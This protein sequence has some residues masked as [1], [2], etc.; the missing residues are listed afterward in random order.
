MDI[1]RVE[2]NTDA[3]CTR[4]NCH[5]KSVWSVSSLLALLQDGGSSKVGASWSH[6]KR[7]APQSTWNT[8]ATCHRGS[9][10]TL[11]ND[12]DHNESKAVF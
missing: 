5:T 3:M 1:Q 12:L 7:F 8:L 10:F 2:A 11:N 9:L 6:S 4:F